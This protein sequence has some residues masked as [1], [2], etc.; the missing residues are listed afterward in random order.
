MKTLGLLSPSTK[1]GLSARRVAASNQSVYSLKVAIIHHDESTRALASLVLGRAS[2]SAGMR[3]FQCTW[4]NID[5][6]LHAR[7]LDDAV[8]AAIAA[9]LIIVALS[10]PGELPPGL[11][12]WVDFWLPRRPQGSGALVALI[13]VPEQSSLASA[14]ARDYLR[15]VARRAHMDFLTHDYLRPTTPSSALVRTHTSRLPPHSLRAKPQL[16]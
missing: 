2:Q 11:C 3:S 12:V 14:Q 7:V 9:D 4:W 6:L 13:G 1:R 15:A 16:A 5:N 10:L 8:Q